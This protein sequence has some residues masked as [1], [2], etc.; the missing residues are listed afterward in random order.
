MNTAKVRR[1]A[2]AQALLFPY[3]RRACR[4]HFHSLQIFDE[5]AASWLSSEQPGPFLFYSNHHYWW[6]GFFELPLIE[7]YQLDYAIMM[8]EKNLRQFSFFRKTG[9]FGVDLE[10]REGRTAGLLR[11]VRFLKEDKLRRSLILYPHGRLI[12]EGGAWPDFEAGL[13]LIARRVPG[14]ALFPVAKKI[15]PGPHPKPE[16]YLSIGEPVF[17]RDEPTAGQLLSRLRKTFVDLETARVEGKEGR[18]WL[19][20]PRRYRGKVQP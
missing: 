19:P 7:S 12:P 15:S 1:R 10:T 2:W 13:E 8:E 17:G 14:L 20:P 11:A 5:P 3:I 18:Y 6:D 4:K 16:V 9:V